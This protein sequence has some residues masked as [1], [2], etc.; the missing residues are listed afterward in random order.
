MA[1]SK[2]Y[3]SQMSLAKEGHWRFVAARRSAMPQAKATSSGATGASGGKRK[4]TEGGEGEAPLSSGLPSAR[5]ERRGL[6][7][8]DEEDAV[9]AHSHLPSPPPPH[10]ARLTAAT[11]I[12]LS[13]P[14]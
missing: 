1:A 2:D 11:C 14:T 9:R 5:G 4:A 8:I 10:S 7:D 13:L 12:P 6:S 3:K